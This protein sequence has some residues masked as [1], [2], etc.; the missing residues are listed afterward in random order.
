[1]TGSD[2]MHE[3]ARA[4]EGKIMVCSKYKLQLFGCWVVVA[5]AVPEPNIKG[6]KTP[7]AI[8]TPRETER[9]RDWTEKH[10][11]NQA[12]NN[13]IK[14]KTKRIIVPNRTVHT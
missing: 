8:R 10:T 11:G 1:M 7:Y 14:E 6:R 4:G 13:K 5:V 2:H 3:C 9:E 12:S